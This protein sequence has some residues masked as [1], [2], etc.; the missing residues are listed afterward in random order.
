VLATIGTQ[1]EVACGDVATGA[2][3]RDLTTSPMGGMTGNMG[4]LPSPGSLPNLG[5]IRSGSMPA[6]PNVA[7]INAMI[8]NVLGTM[9][10]AQWVAAS[11]QLLSVL[12]A[13][14]WRLAASS[15]NPILILAS[16]ASASSQKNRKETNRPTART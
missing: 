7:D 2:R 6:M 4:S 15:Q 5:N 1:G 8:T 16:M 3:L 9:T 10:A 13:G 11:P 14:R 12:T